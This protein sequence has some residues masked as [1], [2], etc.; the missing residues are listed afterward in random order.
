MHGVIRG[1]D[2]RAVPWKVGRAQMA[3][4]W[5]ERERDGSAGV[6]KARLFIVLCELDW[7]P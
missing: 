7:D 4:C 5:D 6:V 3:V 1:R 2:A